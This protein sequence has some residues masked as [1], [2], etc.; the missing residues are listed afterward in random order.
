[1]ADN[2]KIKEPIKVKR[3]I[4]YILIIVFL[5]LSFIIF[6][7]GYSYYNGY[8]K[9]LVKNVKDELISICN[10]KVNQLVLWRK[11]R[12]GDARS[13]LNN[14]LIENEIRDF[15]KDPVHQAGKE[16]IRSW[17]TQTRDSYDYKE[18]A[19]FDLDGNIIF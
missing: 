11:E 16:K 10:L 13:I 4:P 17:L 9:T 5:G 12:L 19:V 2:N 6:F 7:A 1:M 14:S 3:E 8:K 18:V 15:L